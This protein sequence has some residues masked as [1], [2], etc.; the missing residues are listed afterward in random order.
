MNNFITLLL[1]VS[2]GC[3]IGYGAAGIL[4]A[5]KLADLQRQI[6]ELRNELDASSFFARFPDHPRDD[7]TR[8][9]P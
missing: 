7:G 6:A 9:K 3:C 5:A 1:A 8:N 2:G 4:M